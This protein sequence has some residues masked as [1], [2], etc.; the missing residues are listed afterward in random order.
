MTSREEKLREEA[1]EL[2]RA[3]FGEPPP[4]TASGT[5]VLDVLV[6]AAP[7]ADYERLQYPQLKSRGVTWPRNDGGRAGRGA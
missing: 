6:R 7:V 3:L 1:A 4:I 2:W 5:E